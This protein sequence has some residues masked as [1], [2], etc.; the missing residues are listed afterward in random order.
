MTTHGNTIRKYCMLLKVHLSPKEGPREAE[1]ERNTRA[2]G[3]K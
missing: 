3:G 1:K 2:R